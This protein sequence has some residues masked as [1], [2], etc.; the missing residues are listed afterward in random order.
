MNKFQTPNIKSQKNSKHQISSVPVIG[1]PDLFGVWNLLF[2]VSIR[3]K[4]H[5]ILI[6]IAISVL[7][8]IAP[9]GFTKS[10]EERLEGRTVLAYDVSFN[11]I[12]SGTIQWKYLGRET[13]DGKELE[14]LSVSSDTKILAFFDLTSSE[15]VYLDSTTYLPYKV[16]RDILLFGKQESIEEYYYQQDGYVKIVR[17]NE[18]RHEETYQQ[19]KPIH[20]ILALLYFFPDNIPFAPGKWLYFN[21]PTQ[22]IK[23]KM[24]RQ[25]PLRFNCRQKDTYFLLGRGS[26]RFSLW[27]DKQNRLPLRLEFIFPLGKVI[28]TRSDT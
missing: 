4:N 17:T 25:R 8:V 20:N 22:K 5:L 24:V 18:T 16:E 7:L 11:G 10:I 28:I 1:T 2:G 27:L 13:I 6:G 14:V 12:P 15:R 26:K 3:K 9:C 21:L 19:E 23:I